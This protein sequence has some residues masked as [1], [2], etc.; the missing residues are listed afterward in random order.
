MR[1]HEQSKHQK[2]LQP[3]TTLNLD[4]LDQLFSQGLIK[5]PCQKVTRMTQTLMY[6]ACVTCSHLLKYITVHLL[7]LSSRCNVTNVNT[8]SI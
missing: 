5:V 6:A 4:H 3:S 8:G 2:N 7:C 1:D